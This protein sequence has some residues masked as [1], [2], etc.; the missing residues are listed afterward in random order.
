MKHVTALEDDNTF[1]SERMVR[2]GECDPAGIV[3]TP[4]FVDYAVDVGRLFIREI[5]LREHGS[6]DFF[7][8]NLPVK[9]VAVTFHSALYCDDV[10]KLRAAFTRVGKTSFEVSISGHRS[11]TAI[12]NAAVT[13]VSVAASP[14]RSASLPE[15]FRCTVEKNLQLRSS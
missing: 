12:F 11:D 5:T 7:Q 3:Y 15:A 4:N 14:R 13:F 6:P 10:V 2:W 9:N 8:L 1:T